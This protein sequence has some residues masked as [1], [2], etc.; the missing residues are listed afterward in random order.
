MHRF[1]IEWPTNQ[2]EAGHYRK[3]AVSLGS[4]DIGCK[5]RRCFL[6][7][8]EGTDLWIDRR[9]AVRRYV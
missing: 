7:A 1:A 6:G 4:A 2:G 5:I 8:V 3:L 9:R